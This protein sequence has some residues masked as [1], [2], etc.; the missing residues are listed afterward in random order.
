MEGD[1][2]MS[3]RMQALVLHASPSRFH[4]AFLDKI[5]GVL[6][7]AASADGSS[8]NS[9][10]LCFDLRSEEFSSVKFGKAMPDSTTTM[11]NYNGK[12]G[13]LMS[14]DSHYVTRSSTSFKLWVLL[15]AA[16]HE[17]SNHVYVCG[18]RDHV[19]C[20]NGWYK[21][22]RLLPELPKSAFLCHLLQR[23]E[24]D[25]HQSWNPRTGSVSGYEFQN[26]S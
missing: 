2:E 10:V 9:M 4:R 24:K 13:L 19:H 17:W 15:D 12:L 18:F 23:G 5:S 3:L 16:Q 26:L 22:N 21:R 25:D 14:G 6:Y 1:G 7:Y 20:W 11:V 8:E